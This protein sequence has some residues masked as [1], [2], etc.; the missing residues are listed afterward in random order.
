MEA[1]SGFSAPKAREVRAFARRERE[2]S[3]WRLAIRAQNLR[4][5]TRIAR[6]QARQALAEREFWERGGETLPV[7]LCVQKRHHWARSS[8]PRVRFSSSTAARC[9][10][11][12]RFGRLYFPLA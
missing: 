12:E 6:R 5:G 10:R 7:S 11:P 8:P 4:L 9:E 3:G 2:M 1:A